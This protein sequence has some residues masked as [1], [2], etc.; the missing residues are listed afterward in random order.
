MSDLELTHHRH[1]GLPESVKPW[2]EC[3]T[4]ENAAV[5]QSWQHDLTHHRTSD[6]ILKPASCKCDW[7]KNP[8]LML[9]KAG[10]GFQLSLS[11]K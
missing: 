5:F 3:N 2:Q 8:N 4:H 9:Q 1:G 11:L 6:S 7:R 10:G